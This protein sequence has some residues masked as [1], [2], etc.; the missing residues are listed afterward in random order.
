MLAKALNDDNKSA[1]KGHTAKSNTSNNQK[2][3]SDSMRI[4]KVA[5]FDFAAAFPSVAYQWISIVRKQH[6][7]LNGTSII[8][9]PCTPTTL[10]I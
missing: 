8:L 5:F 9:L 6:M 3:N 1:N 10:T 4:A 2:V 7:L